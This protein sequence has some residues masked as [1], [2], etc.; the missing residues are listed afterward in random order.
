MDDYCCCGSG[1][2]SARASRRT[3]AAHGDASFNSL[4]LAATCILLSLLSILTVCLRL[5]L[6]RCGA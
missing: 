1:R 4:H 2:E 3:E 5:D 6:M